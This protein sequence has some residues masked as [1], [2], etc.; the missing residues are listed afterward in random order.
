[1]PASQMSKAGPH[2]FEILNREAAKTA[3]MQKIDEGFAQMPAK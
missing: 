3:I 2:F 1:M